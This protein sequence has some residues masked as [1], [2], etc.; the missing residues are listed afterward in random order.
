MVVTRTVNLFKFATGLDELMLTE[1]PALWLTGEQVGSHGRK[2]AIHLARS[3]VTGADAIRMK[4]G[5]DPGSR[6]RHPNCRILVAPAS[7]TPTSQAPSPKRIGT[8]CRRSLVQYT[9]L[10]ASSA[11]HA[12]PCFSVN[13]QKFLSLRRQKPSMGLISRAKA[14]V[15]SKKI[16]ACGAKSH[17]PDHPG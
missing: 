10:L 16:H 3:I 1:C 17:G 15:A 13:V 14:G 6:N 4:M 9:R 2:L 12:P 7:S 5:A 11:V 8:C